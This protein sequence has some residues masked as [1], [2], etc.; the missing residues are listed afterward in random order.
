MSLGTTELNHPQ[1]IKK[2][3]KEALDE[4]FGPLLLQIAKMIKEM[5]E[6]IN[7]QQSVNEIIAAKINL[8]YSLQSEAQT[9]LTGLDSISEQ[10]DKLDKNLA[11]FL[12]KSIQD[13]KNLQAQLE[14]ISKIPAIQVKPVSEEKKPVSE[15]NLE[16]IP[17]FKPEEISKRDTKQLASNLDNEYISYLIE[18]FS[19][20]EIYTTEALKLIEETRDK[21][22]FERDEE[23]PYRAFGA[24]IFREIL[25]IVKLEKDFR[26]I[27]PMAAQDIKKHL[28]NLR[29]HI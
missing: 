19:K 23:V 4:T 6:S 22:L 20:K 27:S 3:I 2:E 11:K 16:E 21:L 12:Q 15:E 8:V 17:P 10:F 28:I 29:D 24:K 14:N 18:E 7:S 25:S 5:S 13:T 1:D 9:K 26:T